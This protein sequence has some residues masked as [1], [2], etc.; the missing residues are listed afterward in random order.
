MITNPLASTDDLSPQAN[1]T[2]VARLKKIGFVAGLS[3][4]LVTKNNANR[5]GITE[6]EQFNRRRAES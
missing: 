3:L 1:E 4:P 5:Y 2:E 6:V